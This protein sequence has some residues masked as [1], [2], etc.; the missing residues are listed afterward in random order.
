MKYRLIA[1][2]KMRE[3]YMAQAAADFRM[4][5]GRYEEYDEIEVAPGRGSDAGRAVRE[6]GE[7][8]LAALRP[9]DVLWLLDRGGSSLSSLELSARLSGLAD[10]GT[11]RIVFALAGAYGASDALASRADFTWSLSPLTFLHEWARAIVLEQL[12]RA[13]KIARNE[14]YHH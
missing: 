5:L 6:E 3:P 13:A 2:G 1:V 10:S 11:R 9:G 8:I 12:Y 4:R 14:P 7:R